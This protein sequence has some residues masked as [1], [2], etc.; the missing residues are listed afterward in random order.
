M[1]AYMWKG[2]VEPHCNV[3]SSDIWKLTWPATS[4]IRGWLLLYQQISQQM[5]QLGPVGIFAGLCRE[6]RKRAI[7]LRLSRGQSWAHNRRLTVCRNWSEMHHVVQE[8]VPGMKSWKLLKRIKK[9]PTS[10]DQHGQKSQVRGKRR[11]FYVN[12]TEEF[13]SGLIN[14]GSCAHKQQPFDV[15]SNTLEKRHRFVL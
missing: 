5:Q 11:S 7:R 1:S 8:L 6:I 12:E 13:I 10:N 14:S 2:A 4:S 9:N 3:N 15:Y